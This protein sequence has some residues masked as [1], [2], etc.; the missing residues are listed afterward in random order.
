MA[1]TTKNQRIS[2]PVNIWAIPKREWELAEED[3]DGFPF[4]YEIRTNNP[5][6]EG[7][8]KI[9]ETEITVELPGGLD[10]LSAALK[11]LRDTKQEILAEAERRCCE[12]DEKIN[13]L[14]LL[15]YVNGSE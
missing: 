13:K 5:W 7:A 11:T 3:D 2:G 15:E 12:I 8:V 9:H 1:I 4:R 6:V 14:T 10:L